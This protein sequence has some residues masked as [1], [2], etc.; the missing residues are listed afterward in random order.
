M[1]TQEGA[2]LLTRG[3][4]SGASESEKRTLFR[5]KSEKRMRQLEAAMSDTPA[6]TDA[7]SALE[8]RKARRVKKMDRERLD[9]GG[10]KHHIAGAD[11]EDKVPTHFGVYGIAEVR[12]VN[13]LFSAIDDDH[14]GEIDFDEFMS[15]SWAQSGHVAENAESIF[16][17]LDVDGSGTLTKDELLPVIFPKASRDVLAL[18]FKYLTGGF[19]KVKARPKNLTEAQMGELRL[20]FQMY[21]TTGNGKLT[22]EQVLSQM[23]ADGE[24]RSNTARSV[25]NSH[26][27]G[28]SKSTG[29]S[30][31]RGSMRGSGEARSSHEPPTGYNDGYNAG[32]DIKNSVQGQGSVTGSVG[33]G[34]SPRSSSSSHSG[35]GGGGEGGR[36]GGMFTPEDMESIMERYGG[37]T[38]KTVGFDEYVHEEMKQEMSDEREW[39][40]G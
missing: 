18:M 28:S 38:T 1:A 12:A 23:G 29:R 26:E 4:W 10:G 32:N 19:N 24:E 27:P 25:A 39:V 35:G 33:Q 2:T 3:E 7:M 9:G 20:L 15:S 31:M 5:T 11:E 13:Q 30:S 21:D 36:G 22:V 17:S 6:D 16:Y 8:A 40:R 34:G 14:S 37:D